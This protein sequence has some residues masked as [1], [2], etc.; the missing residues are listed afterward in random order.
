MTS[1]SG[2]TLWVL[3]DRNG[4]VKV[5]LVSG[6]MDFVTLLPRAAQISYFVAGRDYV[7]AIDA[8][9]GVLHLIDRPRGTTT[10]QP[11]L[12]IKPMS[13]VVVGLDDRLWI[14]LSDLPYLLAFNPTT[15]RTTT[16]DLG[17]A[18]VSKLAVD[19]QGRILYA[20][21]DRLTVGT[22]DAVNAW[23]SEVRFERRGATTGLVVDR[24]GTLWLSTSAGEIHSVRN[25]IPGLALGL[26]RPVT[27]LSLDED[28][29]AWYLAPLASGAIGYGYA[30]ANGADLVTIGGPASSLDFG[31]AGRVWLADPRGGLYVSRGSD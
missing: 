4:V 14:G 6:H 18:H 10:T 15:G 30:T 5:D 26:Q 23:L 20:D 16:Y 1:R 27:T 8:R 19:G 17:N 13:S 22:Y 12:F 9:S 3:D 31:P 25:K 28:G 24:E 7:Y 11:M 21:D 2:E 29:R